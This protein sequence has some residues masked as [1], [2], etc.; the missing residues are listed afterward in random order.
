[1][2]LVE[3]RDVLLAD[4]LVP[5]DPAFPDAVAASYG[6]E[7]GVMPGAVDEDLDGSAAVGAEIGIRHAARALRRRATAHVLHMREAFRGPYQ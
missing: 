3:P 6:L 4:G 2:V 1:M 7:L 5:P